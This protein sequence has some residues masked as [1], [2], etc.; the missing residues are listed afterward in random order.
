MIRC[1]RKLTHDNR[2]PGFECVEINGMKLSEPRQAYV[3]IQ[4]QLTGKTTLWE[5][6]QK[7]LDK[8]FTGKDS[9]RSKDCITLLV[10]D[11][12]DVLC[13]KRQDVV[14]NLLNWPSQPTAQLVVITIANTMDLPE[15]VLMSRVTSRLGLTRLTFQPYNFK[16]LHEIVITRLNESD[17]FKSDAIQ[18]VARKVA[19]VSGDARR[20][21]DICR[22]ATEIAEHQDSKVVG[23]SHVNEALTEMIASVKVRAIKQC[24]EMERVFLQAVCAEITR[25]GVEETTF[26]NV[27]KQLD[28]L[29]S[30]EGCF[31]FYLFFFF[32][33]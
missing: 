31:F 17:A 3:Q 7:A 15:R 22:R 2:L 16:Q 27:Y 33:L 24:S 12:L 11:E 10:I 1:L 23:I 8:R 19:A 32:R 9:K 20:A 18:L 28:A 13:N 5:E 25:T 21:L 30:F 29:C 26:I 6:A 4:K 14:Y